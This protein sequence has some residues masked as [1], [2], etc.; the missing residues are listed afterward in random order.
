MKEV[1]RNSDLTLLNSSR[2]GEINIELNQSVQVSE[3]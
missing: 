3:K 2:G 1:Q